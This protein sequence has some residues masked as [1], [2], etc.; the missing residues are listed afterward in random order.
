ML[1]VPVIE[2]D[3]KVKEFI[4]DLATKYETLFWSTGVARTRDTKIVLQD[5]LYSEIIL[6]SPE[7][8]LLTASLVLRMANIRQLSSTRFIHNGATHTRFSH[9]VGVS[10]ISSKIFDN[11]INSKEFDNIL[12]DL[13]KY[14]VER[15]WRHLC[16]SNKVYKI[17]EAKWA[18][19]RKVLSKIGSKIISMAGILHDIGHGGWGH[20]MD[21]LNGVLF[22]MIAQVQEHTG[23]GPSLPLSPALLEVQKLDITAASYIISNSE[24][25]QRAINDGLLF[26]IDELNLDDNSIREILFNLIKINVFPMLVSAVITEDETLLVK[27]GRFYTQSL[28]WYAQYPGN[29]RP[30]TDEACIFAIILELLIIIA[31][32]GIEILGDIDTDHG[33][34]GF[35]ADRLDWIRRDKHHLGTCSSYNSNCQYFNE[36][37][38]I[39]KKII[40]EEISENIYFRKD[41]KFLLHI[42]IKDID[43]H[44]IVRQ[45]RSYMYDVYH[46]NLKAIY[47]SILIRTAYSS[48]KLIWNTLVYNVSKDVALRASIAHIM[49]NDELFISNTINVLR[50]AAMLRHV[51]VPILNTQLNLKLNLN[52]IENITCQK[53]SNM[54]NKCDSNCR[55]II[56]MYYVLSSSDEELAYMLEQPYVLMHLERKNNKPVILYDTLF[57][58]RLGSSPNKAIL[59]IELNLE[60]ILPIKLL[61]EKL[62]Q[63]E[64]FGQAY[65]AYFAEAFKS[66]SESIETLRIPLLELLLNRYIFSKKIDIDHIYVNYIHCGLKDLV[67]MLNNI[68]KLNKIDESKIEKIM[69]RPILYLFI[70]SSYDELKSKKEYNEYSNNF[71]NIINNEI[72]IINKIINIWAKY[73]IIENTTED[74]RHILKTYIK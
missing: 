45:L 13:L 8:L 56:D 62:I 44:N 28:V 65:G 25:I 4:T 33:V 70:S 9:S 41:E 72:N 1:K 16:D 71:I 42:Y 66:L 46:N 29:I 51:I 3:V 63:E 74:A 68:N 10:Y 2:A 43:L 58:E 7:S 59:I 22:K 19:L 27:D 57:L 35:N 6:R 20:I 14:R 49:N 73:A 69:K 31:N 60:S 47:D 24:Q 15:H 53:L 34:A 38:E 12:R 30:N 36:L 18:D 21:A 64:D 37:D 54:M 67:W 39:I 52:N 55:Y 50:S 40:H 48:I 61:V 26:Y 5:P 23:S 11:I 17:I 32:I